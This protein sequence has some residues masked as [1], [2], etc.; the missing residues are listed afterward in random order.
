MASPRDASWYAQPNVRSVKMIH[1]VAD[2]GL[3]SRCGNPMLD[4]DGHLFPAAEVPERRRCQR[5]GCRQAWP[6]AGDER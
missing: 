1:V 5:S 6:Q 2:D 4:V 3:S